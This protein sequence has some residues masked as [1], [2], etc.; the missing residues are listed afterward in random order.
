MNQTELRFYRKLANEVGIR[1]PQCYYAMEDYY[2]MHFL[3]I[4]EDL[5]SFETGENKKK[6][7]NQMGSNHFFQIK[8]ESSGFDLRTSEK[9]IENIA[10]LH[11]KFWNLD[12][13]KHRLNGKVWSHGGYWFGGKEIRN[14]AIED[15][16]N[17]SNA[18]LPEL[19]LAK[20]GELLEFLVTHE[21]LIISA[22]H[23]FSPVTL[24]HGDYKITNL[25]VDKSNDS[26]YTIDWQWLGA[27]V[28]A[29]DVAYFI[30]TSMREDALSS[31]D[32]VEDSSHYQY[33]RKSEFDLLNI[34][35]KKLNSL[36]VNQ[37]VSENNLLEFRV[38]EQQYILNVIYFFIFCI[39]NKYSTM[40]KQNFQKNSDEKQ[41]GLH[42]RSINHAK[43]LL[44][45]AYYFSKNIDF[46]LLHQQRQHHHQKLEKSNS[47]HF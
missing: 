39:K 31:M 23:E 27:G 36:L 46:Q 38:F 28:G 45:R 12:L 14:I 19:E 34:Y 42:L 2:N 41:D 30:Y 26:I 44:N 32:V 29:T 9:I 33:H 3:C 8:G 11:A 7:S 21:N 24:I 1:S 25:F 47:T 20:Y 43:R 17:K 6:E 40:N 35:F 15:A 4:L 37:N 16:W 10:I 18:N 13:R 5:T 22:V